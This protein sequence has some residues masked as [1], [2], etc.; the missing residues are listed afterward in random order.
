[1]TSTMLPRTKSLVDVHADVRAVLTVEEKRDAVTPKFEAVFG[2]SRGGEKDAGTLEE[3]GGYED[4][5]GG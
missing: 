5:G 1:M 3:E 4:R 2:G